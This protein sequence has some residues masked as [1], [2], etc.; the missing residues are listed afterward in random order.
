MSTAKKKAKPSFPLEVN[1]TYKLTSLPAAVQGFDGIF[2]VKKIKADWVEV[3]EI[4]DKDGVPYKTQTTF[5]FNVK[6]IG[7]I[8]PK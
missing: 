4:A 1:K 7:K 5:R 2:K 8:E 6:D 3:I